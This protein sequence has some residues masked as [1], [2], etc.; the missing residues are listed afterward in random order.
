MDR[1]ALKEL[2]RIGNK[3]D[4]GLHGIEME[5]LKQ[6][7]ITGMEKNGVWKYIIMITETLNIKK[8]YIVFNLN[9]LSLFINEKRKI[10]KLC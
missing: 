4:Y 10:K 1:K 5:I 2:I 7:R 9:N 3:M 6:K 8:Y